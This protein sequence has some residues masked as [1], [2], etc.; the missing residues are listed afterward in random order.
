VDRQIA[1]SL[2]T[3]EREAQMASQNRGNTL[4]DELGNAVSARLGAL[5]AAELQFTPVEDAVP[6][7]TFAA[8]LDSV[9]R[10]HIGLSAISVYYPTGRIRRPPSGVLGMPGAR[11]GVDTAVTRA[12]DRAIATRDLAATRVIEVEGFTRRVLIFD[13][14][15]RGDS[16]LG[17]LVA[18]L[19]PTGVLRAATSGPASQSIP[20]FY[21]VFD[22]AGT[23]IT[24]P[25]GMP[26]DWLTVDR[27]VRVADTEWTVRTAYAPVSRSPYRTQR[28]AL[29]TMG[30]ILALAAGL[31]L[32]LLRRTIHRQ[33]AE[34]V[35]REQ[36]ERAAQE[37]AEEASRRALEARELAA[38]LEAAQRAAERLSTALDPD[39]VVEQFLGA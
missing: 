26:Q 10:R 18:E 24:S 9:T 15:F 31:L 13:P 29:W 33:K 23:R 1:T 38:Q 2:A 17:T 39:E 36:A 6:E 20:S 11:V 5:S 27:Q 12:Y 7:R 30:V 16:L 8:A 37:A 25:T 22:P 19:E 21:A 35:R 32:G 34:L 3:R 28:I 14:V 4:A